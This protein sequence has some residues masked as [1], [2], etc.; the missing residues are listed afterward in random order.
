MSELPVLVIGAGPIGLAAATRLAERGIPALVL[1]RGPIAGA[2]VSEWN[3]VRLF[4]RW[5]ELIDPAARQLLASTGW[6]EPDPDAYPTGQDWATRYLQPLA[7]ALG[8]EVVRTGTTV[9]AITRQSRDRVVD[10]GRDTAPLVVHATSSNGSTERILAR[11]VIDASGTW[12]R[13]NPLG[14]EGIPAI[15]E[16]AARDGIH[17]RIPDLTDPGQRA[18]LLGKHIAIAGSGHSALTA[19]GLLADLAAE[20]PAT[21]ITW[22]L[23]RASS[24][25]DAATN[26]ELPQRGALGI[27]AR[28]AVDA[29]LIHPRPGF[30]VTEIVSTGP[31]LSLISDD[32][33]RLDGVDTVLA[34]TGFRPD[35]RITSEL[36]L[37]LD[38]VLEAPRALAPLID[39]NVHSCGTVYPHGHRELAHPEPGYFIAGMKSY[40]RAPTFLAL[41]GYE[42]VRSIVAAID[43]DLAAAEAVELTLPETGVCGGAGVFD[44]PDAASSGGCCSAPPAPAELLALPTFGGR[45]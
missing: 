21:T 23:R 13:P 5:G 34:L 39:P 15:G 10:S 40:G 14:T 38:P 27:R 30:R 16:T 11:A 41:T 43:G 4:S 20:D 12:S 3:H 33:Q 2:A 9:T 44:D 37:D 42:Q 7:Q 17:Y 29:G 18:A 35:H 6:T 31:G 8:P 25:P 24:Q 26:D 19:I 32:G 28:E 22:I 45:P 1:E 36:R